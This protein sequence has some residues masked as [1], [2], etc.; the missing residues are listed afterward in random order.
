MAT[1]GEVARRDAA[2]KVLK[3]ELDRNV[4]RFYADRFTHGDFQKANRA[5]WEKIE[6]TG[7]EVVDEVLRLIR[8]DL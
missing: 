8:A 5:T 3:A 4:D 2:A 7:T 6:A 1:T